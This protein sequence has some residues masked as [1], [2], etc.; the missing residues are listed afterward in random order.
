MKRVAACVL[1]ALLTLTPAAPV[2]A[3]T[4]LSPEARAA[5]K[6]AKAQRKEMQRQAKAQRKELKRQQRNQL[7]HAR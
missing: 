2:Y 7:G 4:P 6:R 5:Q 1:L 3:R